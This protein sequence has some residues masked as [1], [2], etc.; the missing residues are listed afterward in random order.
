MNCQILALPKAYQRAIRRPQGDPIAANLALPG[1]FD[2]KS[3][4]KSGDITSGELSEAQPPALN[5]VLVRPNT[6]S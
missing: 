5:L 2:A 6:L 4:P 3:K 1:A